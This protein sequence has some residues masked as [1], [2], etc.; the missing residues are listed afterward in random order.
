[1]TQSVSPEQYKRAPRLYVA[2]GAFASGAEVALAE[3]QRHY[4]TAVMRLPEGGVV[5][6]FNGRDGEWLAELAGKKKTTRLLLREK[7]FE[8]VDAADI[9]AIASPVKKDAFE[10]MIEK[11]TELGASRFVP[12]LCDHTAVRRMN[13]ARAEAIAIEA[14]EQCERFDVPSVAPL[15]ALRE[16][17]EGWD[18]A[19]KILF[20]LERS[21][22][23]P[24]SAA[25]SEEPLA[26]L[27]GPEGGFSAVEI[28]YI[29]A[30]PFVVPVSLGAG[31]LRAE[32]ALIAALSCLRVMRSV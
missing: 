28:D 29:K 8:Q 10:L 12:V 16:V 5:R 25:V 26:V 4:L 3:G 18:P 9:W 19:R 11:A 13:A 21:A 22:A 31:I 24:L 32:T 23:P 7:I 1:M 14:A 6:V 2:E 17:L 27:V 30:L 15:T 20:C